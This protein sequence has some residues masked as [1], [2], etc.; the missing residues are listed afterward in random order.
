[1]ND[2]G[3]LTQ[4]LD[5]IFINYRIALSKPMMPIIIMIGFSAVVV[6]FVLILSI[7]EGLSSTFR[8][9]GSSDV[10]IVLSS[11]AYSESESHLSG[12]VVAAIGDQ[13]GIEHDSEGP[14]I[15]PE[16][17]TTVSLLKHGTNVMAEVIMRGVTNN[18]FKVHQ[19][20]HLIAGRLF[21]PGVHEAIV[22]KQAAS[23]Y[24]NLKIGNI[25]K[26]DNGTWKVVGIFAANSGL[27]E[28]EI[29][30]DAASL[31]TAFHMGN[32]YSDA[33]VRLTT[34]EALGLFIAGCKKDPRLDVEVFSEQK[35]FKQLAANYSKMITSIG[36]LFA[37]LMGFGAT[38]GT[39]NLMF[40]SMIARRREMAM[41]R[42]LG[43]SR[44]SVSSAVLFEV[45]TYGL[46]GGIFASMATYF[47]FNGYQA[48]TT[49]GNG[50]SQVAFEFAV[51]P[52]LLLIGIAITLIMGFI[53]GLIPAIHSARLPLAHALREN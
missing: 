40:I 53:G 36:L 14:L 17:M 42:A 11:A 20:V 28:S 41:L 23:E 3:W 52:I 10:A 7:G 4:A 19:R 12:E 35:Y 46:V 13:P 49:M 6:V 45:M 9:S 39:I 21:T 27:R 50:F 26:S 25:I 16:F 2:K 48:G 34:P 8:N 15:S 51:T 47:A 32:S 18:A 43:F 30:T 22:G 38:I 37:T 24:Q 31:Q 5:I 33:Y 44:L 1:M 29:W